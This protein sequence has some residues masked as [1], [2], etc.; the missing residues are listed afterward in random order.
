MALVDVRT[1]AVYRAIQSWCSM[2]S[3]TT[4]WS[5]RPASSA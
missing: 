1:L 4:H 5:S 3:K 2:T